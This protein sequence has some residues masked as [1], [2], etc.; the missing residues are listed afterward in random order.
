MADITDPTTFPFV[1]I[2]NKVDLEASRKISK[3]ECSNMAR[4]LREECQKLR[5]VSFGPLT[6]S[7]TTTH[8]PTTSPRPNLTRTP[9]SA[10]SKSPRGGRRS[11]RAFGVGRRLTLIETERHSIRPISTSFLLNEILTPTAVQRPLSHRA[12]IASYYTTASEGPSEVSVDLT[13]QWNRLTGHKDAIAPQSESGSEWFV[14][15][16]SEGGIQD[17]GSSYTSSTVTPGAASDSGSESDDSD[18]GYNPSDEEIPIS[19]SYTQYATSPPAV[20]RHT[21]FYTTSFDSQQT[22]TITNPHPLPS[23]PLPTTP[24]IPHQQEDLQIPL[25]EVSAKLGIRIDD[26]FV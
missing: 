17:S 8:P 26:A 9:S 24:S 22:P 16:D 14:S 15:A 25:F 4:K 2:G 5:T 19:Q 23:P 7:L 12:S 13:E 3:R 11:K 20:F 18:I 1:L 10:S 21:S 6:P